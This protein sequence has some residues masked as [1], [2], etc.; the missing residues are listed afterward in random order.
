MED[1]CYTCWETE[2]FCECEEGFDSTR[3]RE[4]ANDFDANGPKSVEEI[5]DLRG[6]Y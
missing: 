4:K 6:K 1:V 2:E 3:S 5:N